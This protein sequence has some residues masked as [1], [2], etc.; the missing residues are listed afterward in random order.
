MDIDDSLCAR[1]LHPRYILTDIPTRAAETFLHAQ[2]DNVCSAN[3]ATVVPEA[4]RE[5]PATSVPTS[6]RIA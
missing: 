5:M 2:I 3:E 1:D 4:H 6:L